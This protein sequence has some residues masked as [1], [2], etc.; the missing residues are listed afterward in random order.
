MVERTSLLKRQGVK[1]LAG[2]NPAGSANNMLKIIKNDN[3]YELIDDQKVL[4]TLSMVPDFGVGY[5]GYYLDADIKINGVDFYIKHT[6][7]Q[8][9]FGINQ[10]HSLILLN[11]LNEVLFSYSYESAILSTNSWSSGNF[12][13]EDVYATLNEAKYHYTA[14]SKNLRKIS[15]V[16]S[17]TSRLWVDQNQEEIMSFEILNKLDSKNETLITTKLDPQNINT[18]L[19]A[20]WGFYLLPKKSSKNWLLI[21]LGIIFVVIFILDKFIF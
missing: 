16:F 7:K 21:L 5:K 6:F 15:S 13:L 12:D 11:N 18:I 17:S 1:A 9:D 14:K 19:L 2:S 8:L 10:E 3:L 4:G 20:I